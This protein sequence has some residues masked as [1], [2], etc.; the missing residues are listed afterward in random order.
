MKEP[1]IE[2]LAT[3]NDPE[4]CTTNREVG[5]EALTRARTGRVWSPEISS[6]RA[7]T[8][9]RH[10]EGNTLASESGL[11]AGGSAGSKTPRMCGIS[12]GENKEIRGLSVTIAAQ[13]ASGRPE[14]ISR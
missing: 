6:I 2:G 4:S 5:R 13:A 11:L 14:V 8:L 10:A 12:M 1:Y 9:L 7:P 3:H